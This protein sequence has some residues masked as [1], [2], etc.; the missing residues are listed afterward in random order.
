MMQ[1]TLISLLLSLL[2]GLPLGLR[3]QTSDA[4]PEYT[5]K[6]AYLYNFALLTTWPAST[7]VS[8]SSFKLCLYG[9]DEFGPALDQLTGKDVNG[10]KVQVSRIERPED[11]RQCQ[12]IFISE[13]NTNRI[14]RLVSALGD[15]P[16]LTVA[17]DNLNRH[18]M[19]SLTPENKRLTFAINANATKAA[20]LQLSSK[21]LRLAAHVVAP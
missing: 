6:A 1:R 13:P 9:P 12:L 10:Q 7:G 17:D 15:K 3:A 4:V 20:N 21:L 19:I 5:M 2:I 18:A 14:M 16:V 8:D 11:A